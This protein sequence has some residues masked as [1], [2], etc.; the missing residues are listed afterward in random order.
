VS[1][2]LA[3]RAIRPARPE[4]V[5]AIVA[6]VHELAEYERAPE[7]C[8]LSAAQLDA[9]LFGERPALFGHVGVDGDDRPIAYALWFL[10]FSTWEGVHGIYLEDLYVRP[11]ARGTGLGRDLLAT[12]AGLCVERGYAR[13]EWWVLHWNPARDFYAAIGAAAM[14][15][16]VP[17]RLT[18]PALHRLATPAHASAS[19]L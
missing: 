6:M 7:Q 1:D 9:A 15:E 12:L 3:Q 13:L 17:Y 2:P 19:R 11:A 14:D 16:W 5:P 18:G 10:N 8:H 4:D